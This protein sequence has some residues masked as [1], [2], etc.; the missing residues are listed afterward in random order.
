MFFLDF[1]RH[2]GYDSKMAKKKQRTP[3]QEALRFAHSKPEKHWWITRRSF[4]GSAHWPFKWGFFTDWKSL[5]FSAGIPKV[6]FNSPDVPES[7][8][9]FEISVK[10]LRLIA[11]RQNRRVLWWGDWAWKR[12]LIEL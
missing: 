9:S 10:P 12:N 11:F 1:A 8:F 5:S 6:K 4:R 2:V 3:E 7:V